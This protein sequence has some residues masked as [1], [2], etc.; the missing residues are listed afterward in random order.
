MKF[1]EKIETLLTEGS[2]MH[3]VGKILAVIDAQ[4]AD[5]I[6]AV[7]GQNGADDD[8]I[9]NSS[10]ITK[11]AAAFRKELKKLKKSHGKEEVWFRGSYK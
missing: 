3:S 6:K 1:E 7:K 8:A 11:P 4:L 2:S 5:L 10:E 9:E